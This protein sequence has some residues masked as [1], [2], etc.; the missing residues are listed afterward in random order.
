MRHFFCHAPSSPKQY[1]M[2]SKTGEIRRDGACLDYAGKDVILFSCHGSKGNQVSHLPLP[3]P[4]LT[5][6]LTVSLSR[7]CSSGHI[8]RTQSSCATAPL[9]S[10]WPSTRP[11]TSWSWRSATRATYASSGSWRT[12]TAANCEDTSM[13]RAACCW[14]RRRAGELAKAEQQQQ[15]NG[16]R[17]GI[18]SV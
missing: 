16:E 1:W 6:L 14:P 11:R 7:F 15:Q 13:R 3:H 9:A 4:P 10:A 2:L 17:D 18:I 5:P 8:A 12:T